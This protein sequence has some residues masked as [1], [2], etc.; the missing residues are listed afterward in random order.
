VVLLRLWWRSYSAPAYKE[1]WWERLGF[2]PFRFD[3]SLWVHTVSVGE[4]I[5][6]LPLLKA[7]RARYP[8]LPLLVTTMTP[9]GAARVKSTLKDEVTHAYLPYDLPDAVARFLN[10]A[11]PVIGIVMETE[12]WP[13]LF[14]AC[15]KRG[16]PL[17]LLNA[18]L[19]EKSAQGYQRVDALTKTILQSLYAI[20]AQTQADASRFIA[21]GMPPERISITGNIKFDIELPA[22]LLQQAEAL[23]QH[24]GKERFIWI[25]ASTHQGEE[26]IILAAHQALREQCPQALLILVPRHPERFKAVEQQVKQCGLTV[27][28][29]SESRPC[30]AE[31]AV[32]LGDTMGELLLLYGAAEVAFVGGSFMP[33]GGH[34]VLEPAALGKAIITGESCFNFVEACG[35]LSAAQALYKVPDASVLAK[36]LFYLFTHEDQRIKMGANAKAVVAK[37]RGALEKQ[38]GIIQGLKIQ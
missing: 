7:L 25:A 34:N 9:T 24:L 1:R 4:T 37:N 29:R 38:L 12:L 30:T 36:Q 20:G 11:K 35:L 26:E 3:K 23:R 8:H 33:I 19:S 10:R 27:V 32:Y 14:V 21:L 28:T 17:L 15:H 16:I 31:T 13:N 6:A 22:N 2:Y 18:R 5:A